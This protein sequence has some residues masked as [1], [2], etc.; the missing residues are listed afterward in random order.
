MPTLAS[1]ELRTCLA[2]CSLQIR[3]SEH[4]SSF[5][6]PAGRWWSLV[7]SCYANGAIVV[8]CGRVIWIVNLPTTN[9][10]AMSLDKPSKTERKK[11]KKMKKKREATARV[12]L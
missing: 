2:P 4:S 11:K 7:C 3:A 5:V 8:L 6:A 1:G 10:C 12:E 9:S